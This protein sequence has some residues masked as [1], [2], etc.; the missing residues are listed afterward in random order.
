MISCEDLIKG[1]WVSVA[2]QDEIDYIY[3]WQEYSWSQGAIELEE[4]KYMCWIEAWS[5]HEVII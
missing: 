4:V 5:I 2:S 3:F 1:G